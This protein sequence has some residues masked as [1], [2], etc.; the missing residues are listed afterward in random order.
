ML[1]DQSLRGRARGIFAAL[2]VSLSKFRFQ[3]FDVYHDLFGVE[4]M[5]FA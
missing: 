5:D 3:A 4:I 2:A 1:A